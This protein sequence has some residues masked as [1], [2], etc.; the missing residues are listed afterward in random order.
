[1]PFLGLARVGGGDPGRGLLFVAADVGLV[2]EGLG[3]GVEAGEE[4]LALGFGNLE[5]ER[6]MRAVG[7]LKREGL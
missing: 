3:D 2:H 7:P 5:C 1:M 4:P 6:G